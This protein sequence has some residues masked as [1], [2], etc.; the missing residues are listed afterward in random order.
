MVSN[1]VLYGLGHVASVT[2]SVFAG[3]LT[4]C[5]LICT[6]V[7]TW[8]IFGAV[9]ALVA[10]HV[11]TALLN[12]ACLGFAYSVTVIVTLSDRSPHVA[13]TTPMPGLVA[14]KSQL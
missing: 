11:V 10:D 13:V 6:I 12:I 2:V 9:W 8:G 7:P 4:R 3:N 1:G 5:I 14:L